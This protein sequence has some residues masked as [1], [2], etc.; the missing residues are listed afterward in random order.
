MLIVYVNC[1]RRLPQQNVTSWRLTVAT[2][3]V[4]KTLYFV[5]DI[6]R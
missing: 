5:V 4:L 3:S 6:R 2:Y 1:L